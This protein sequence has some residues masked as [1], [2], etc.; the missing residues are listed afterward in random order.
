VA[1]GFLK[2][3]DDLF[4]LSAAEV[5]G[6]K[7]GRRYRTDHNGMTH[8]TLQQ[9]I[10]G[11][12]VFQ[13]AMTIH[14][15]REGSV[16]AAGGEL[17]PGAAQATNLAEPKITA[18]EALRSAAEQAGAEVKE[19]PETR[20]SPGGADAR[21][22]F[23]SGQSF[24][25]DVK[26]R[27]VYFPLAANRM[28]LA[29]EFV[30]WMRETP[31][32][33]LILIDAEQ[34]TLL[35]RHNLTD[36]EENPLRPHGPVYTGDSP[37]PD[38]PHTSDSPPIVDRQDLPFRSTPYNGAPTFKRSDPH[39]DWWAGKPATG[40]ISNNT[41]VRLDR[42]SVFDQPDLPRLAAPIGNF[43]F[44]VDFTVEPTAAANQRAAQVNLFYWINRYH[45]ILYSFGFNEAAG[46]FQTDNFGLGGLGNDAVIGDAQDNSG[47]NN[48]NFTTPPDGQPG[49]VQMFL[50]TL[51]SP[52]LDGSFDQG[53]ILH[54]LTHGLTNRL[55]GDALGLNPFQSRGMGEGWSDY[56]SLT[57]LRNENDDPGASYPVG[58]Y[59]LNDYA[60]GIRRFPYSTNLEVNPLTFGG[61]S[62]TPFVHDVGEIWC[63]MLWEMRASL[64]ERYGFREGQRQSVQLVV[65]GLKM[66]P[67][68]PTFID[69]RDAI[70]LADQ[71][72]NRGANQCLIWKAFA[73]RGLGF[74]AS[75]LDAEDFAPVESFDVAPSCSATASLR[76]DKR[77]Y[78]DNETVRITLGDSNAVAPVLVNVTSSRTGDRERIRLKPDASIPG[79][80]TGAVRLE[81]RRVEAGD[82]R[83]Q[84]S[85]EAVDQ[86]GV[87]YIDNN[88]EGGGSERITASAAWT[89][90]LAILDDNVERGNQIWF[91]SGTWA[92]TDELAGSPTRSWR[93]K[94]TSPDPFI[95]ERLH[96]TSLPLDL[97][98]LTEVTLSFSQSRQMIGGLHYG[99]VEIS[100]DDGATWTQAGSFTNRQDGFAT[101]RLLL[102]GLEGQARARL[103]FRQINSFFGLFEPAFWA[104]D[105]IRLTARS[106][107]PQIIPPGDAPAPI[108]TSIDPAFG[109]P[110]GGTQVIISG[111]NFTE[112]EDTKVTFDGTPATQ[113]TVSGSSAIMAV[114][115]PHK[116]GP[117]TVRVTNR[118]GAFSQTK[119][120]TYYKPGGGGLPV[121][122]GVLPAS[123][124]V[125]GGTVATL[126]GAN[127]TPET[128]VLFGSKEAPVTFVN[129]NTLR[130]VAPAAST[131]GAVDV[132][133]RNGARQTVLAS[134]FSY[135]AA[136]PPTVQVLSP[137][138]V[139]KFYTG[140]ALP[141]RWQSSDNREVVKHRIRLSFVPF[142]DAPDFKIF[143]DIAPEVSGNARSF[144][145]TIPGHLSSLP[146][147][148]IHVT[149]IDDE[150]A[151]TE[152]VSGQFDI[153]QRWEAR[154]LLP[155]LAEGQYIAGGQYFYVIG[156]TRFGTPPEY[157]VQRY[158]PEADAWTSRALAP[159]PFD[160]SRHS[161]SVFLNGK[162]Y[163]PGGFDSNFN[164]SPLHL[165]YDV[166]ANTFVNQA[167]VPTATVDYA[168]A[169]DET[170]GVYYHTG[171]FF[172]RDGL[173][174]TPSRA[175]RMYDTNTN[176]WTDLPPMNNVRDGHKA[177]L[178]EGKLY[179]AGG[180][181][182][183]G[184]SLVGEV[185]DFETGNWSPIAPLNRLRHR[186]AA[187][188]VKDAAGNPFWLFVGDAPTDP[189]LNAE[190]YDVRN[191]R[192]IPLDN[193]FSMPPILHSF[194][195]LPVGRT[196]MGGGAVGDF[197][198]VI[199][200]PLPGEFRNE[201]LLVNPL[202]LSPDNQP[203]VLAVPDTQ[204]GKAGAEIKF[205][206]SASDFGSF[207]PITITANELPAGA[208]FTTAVVNNNRTLGS[209]KW[210]P[211][212]ADTGRSFNVS[213]TAS[214]GQLSDTKQVTI[215]VVEAAP[216]TLAQAGDSKGGRLA[217]DSI[218]AA[219]GA[220]LAADAKAAQTTRLPF[221]IAGTTVTINGIRAPIF[222]VS[223][224][225]VNFLVPA[226]IKPGSATVV[227]RNAAGRYSI[228]TTQ[229]VDAAPAIFTPNA[230]GSDEASLLS[231]GDGGYMRLPQFRAPVNSR[232][233]TLTMYGTGIR[234]VQATNPKDENGVAESVN[235]T[236]GG[237]PA[238]VLYAGAHGR[239]SGLDQITVEIPAEAAGIGR[240]EVVVSVN[241]VILN[242]AMRSLK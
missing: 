127:F 178:I 24:G 68:S 151:E 99:L 126:T 237:R 13:S 60:R 232:P 75:T 45:D 82:G 164:I 155:L 32:A 115:P 172:F 136:T 135:I 49:R 7:E 186:P 143:T 240:V 222:S 6:L 33:Y 166:A 78:V 69:A 44:P 181:S 71:V 116:A 142:A 144:T 236:I 230:D 153:A 125:Q 199:T 47:L 85:D 46:N 109:P 38:S 65:D 73:K 141:I 89:R 209:F 64:I 147:S 226:T 94:N 86:I 227:I 41:D 161:D 117:V 103:R 231:M 76:L 171:G 212:P 72:N 102:R 119:G 233:N 224:D 133:A 201:R 216:L 152:A 129:A 58:Q 21:Q 130:A 20:V 169:A 1:R 8:L 120:F 29:W 173:F 234:R 242:R 241:G 196:L 54:E 83:L 210:T 34:K 145:W 15:N 163:I 219:F 48:A 18:V 190:V 5:D 121:L 100:T 26:A 111:A 31:D 108:I 239:S 43:S 25:Q 157:T 183:S 10:G 97:T 158:D 203:P 123:G 87:V 37:R 105:D 218:C 107:D 53:V 56:F 202:E 90:E 118:R 11:V 148:R 200:N 229:I 225:R 188:V 208:E 137:E 215:R 211:T 66:T 238:R 77:S 156:Q 63:S 9:Q 14:V 124:S 205:T 221:D 74:S 2:A 206:V 162:I 40:L 22:E 213:F 93:V 160:L 180:I 110:A 42:D 167:E 4:R 122:G 193:S 27:L 138:G 95:L 3:N 36:Y 198:H 62:G 134:A 177:A 52:Q 194:D 159:P 16:I 217:A 112:S 149:A 17:I 106:A 174:F 61:I 84:G 55:V 165:A 185:F 98:G 92:I 179:V 214:D 35:F 28:R 114:T 70:L 220:D 235:V 187:A 131:V 67:S 50:W 182:E 192:W 39:Y 30:I 168:V 204:V 12:E 51:T 19:R 80:F 207:A 140:A 146:R 189:V 197:L 57:L 128:A 79:S 150:G 191:D 184:D 104:I 175:V 59:V 91:P 176:T 96:L 195:G 101:S 132:T 81:D 88:T 23:A 113:V 139:E 154:A 170:R 228:G 223:P